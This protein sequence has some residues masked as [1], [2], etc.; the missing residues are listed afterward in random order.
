MKTLKT[1][2]EED[3]VKQL[4]QAVEL[5]LHNKNESPFF[6]EKATPLLQAIYSVILPLKAQDL[7]FNPEGKRIEKFD[8]DAFMRWTDLVSLKLLYFT[9]KESNE[10]GQLCRTE[11]N[12]V[13]YTP[14]DLSVLTEYM[15]R[16]NIHT[17]YEEEDFAIAH[18]NMHIGI[19]SVIKDAL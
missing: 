1:M 13:S 6:A 4:T 5:S 14:V 3:D 17:E 12:D 18:Y 15:K 16:Y 7:L 11:Y 10:K 2:F 8:F 19:A 9:I